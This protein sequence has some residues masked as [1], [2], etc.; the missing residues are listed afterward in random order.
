[1]IPWQRL[2][3][4]LML[5]CT[6]WLYPCRDTCSELSAKIHVVPTVFLLRDHQYS[7]KNYLWL[8]K[9]FVK[10]Q[11]CVHIATQDVLLIKYESNFYFSKLTYTVLVHA[12]LRFLSFVHASPHCQ[13]YSSTVDEIHCSC[14]LIQWTASKKTY[15]EGQKSMYSTQSNCPYSNHSFSIPTILPYWG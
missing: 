9:R 5:I 11:L 12:D 6:D 13:Q 14:L 4:F 1:M 10:G 8:E 15:R 2:L 7:P 3:I